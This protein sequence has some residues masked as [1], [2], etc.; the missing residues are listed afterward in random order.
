[1]KTTSVAMILGAGLA[2]ELMTGCVPFGC[3]APSDPTNT[4]TF[5][6]T[7]AG[8]VQMSA[9]VHGL[10]Y[11]PGGVWIATNG[12]ITE[13]TALGGSTIHSFDLAGDVRGV[14]WDGDR[15]WV[16]QGTEAVAV[17]PVLGPSGV[18]IT[19]PS[20][21]EDLA[22]YDGEGLMFA[23]GLAAFQ[24]IDPNTQQID[25]SVPVHKLDAVAAVAYHD[26]ETW[27]AQA[28][29]PILVYDASGVLL[30]TASADSVALDGRTTELHLAFDG[31]TLV[32]ARGDVVYRYAI[33]RTAPPQ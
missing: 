11:V 30:A 27:V 29:G 4:A 33:D 25:V 28:G 14:A 8:T 18:S 21:A 10:A 6:L 26:G 13:Q 20:A 32:I 12:S 16:G 9:P 22:W 19:L 5:A 1:M 17:D 31:E 23:A 7:G 2:A 24:I 15:V 3:G